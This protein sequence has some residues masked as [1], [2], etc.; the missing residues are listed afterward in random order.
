MECSK[1]G[2]TITHVHYFLTSDFYCLEPKSID[3][4]YGSRWITPYPKETYTLCIS[5]WTKVKK[6]LEEG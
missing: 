3:D 2:K 5:C 1:C 4:R 6:V